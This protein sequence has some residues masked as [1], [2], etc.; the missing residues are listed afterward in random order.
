MGL[1]LSSVF[2]RLFGK[3]QMR[4]LMGEPDSVL[5]CFESM[6][7]FWLRCDA[8]VMMW[9]VLLLWSK[10]RQILSIITLTPKV[11]SLLKYVLF[12]VQTKAFIEG[13]FIQ[14]FMNAHLNGCRE[15]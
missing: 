8:H 3:K 9:T 5:Y 4:I 15:I 2:G 1:T 11:D 7:H 13:R 12:L 14:N 10:E 6:T